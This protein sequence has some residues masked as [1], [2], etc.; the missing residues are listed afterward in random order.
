MF[1]LDEVASWMHDALVELEPGQT[2]GV[3]ELPFGCSILELVERRDF[4]PISFEQAR[5]RL[6][7]EV[8]QREMEKNYRVWLEQLRADTYID[9]RG[10]FADAGVRL[11][12]RSQTET[13]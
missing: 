3:L 5:D 4:E 12:G 2:S 7:Q 9:R 13:P 1:H 10:F 6:S 11:G 8:W